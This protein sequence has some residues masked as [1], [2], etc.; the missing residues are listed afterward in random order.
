MENFFR[1]PEIKTDLFLWLCITAVFS[2]LGFW[3]GIKVG[4]LVLSLGVVTMV[5]HFLR[6]KKR[7]RKI[8]KLS[9]ELDAMLHYQTPIP[10]EDYTEGELSVL[11]SELSKMTLRLVEQAD[12]LEQDKVYLSD[13]MADISHQLRSPLTA[14]QLSLSLL[15]DPKTS[16]ERKQSLYR[17]LGQLLARINWL[18]ESL[19][20]MSKMDAGTAYLV[21]EEVPVSQLI[22]EASEPLLVPMELREQTLTVETESGE[23]SFLGDLAWTTEAVQNVLKNCMEHTPQGGHV[24][25]HCAEN[26]IYTE[27]VIEDNGSGFAKEDLPHIFERFYK[28][29]ESGS[30]SVG[31]GLALA[32]MIF[33][34]QNATIKAENRTEGG[35]RF[36]VRFYK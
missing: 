35:A 34:Q 16:E 22:K 24:W 25:V 15:K 1:N 26:A 6:T 30:Q 17:E 4:I 36:V 18:V 21:K 20:K 9:G 7:Y 8:K 14:M 13:T 32:R 3:M 28:G 19:L 31:I 10:F 33:A 5:I 27:L 12:K 2:A 23:E 11:Q 29:K